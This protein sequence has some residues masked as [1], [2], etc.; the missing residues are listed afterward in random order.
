MYTSFSAVSG[1]MQLRSDC[2]YPEEWM[3]A[4]LPK[5]RSLAALEGARE[6]TF[7][8]WIPKIMIVTQN[9]RKTQAER[10]RRKIGPIQK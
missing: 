7:N 3:K 10:N 2:I 4:L 5:L 6:N 1:E 9:R 8:A